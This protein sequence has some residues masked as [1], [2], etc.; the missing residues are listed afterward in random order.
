[1]PPNHT[2]SSAL[3]AA[4]L[5]LLLFSAADALGSASTLAVVSGSSTVCGITAGKSTQNISCSS[6]GSPVLPAVPFDSIS[7]GRN[8]FCGVRS[9]GLSLLCWNTTDP[10]SAYR[11]KRIYS[12]KTATVRLKDPAVGDDHV[13]AIEDNGSGIVRCWRG[14]A[15]L[16]PSVVVSGR[17]Q[18]VTSGRGFSCG[19]TI[20]DS[21]VRCWG[22]SIAGE[23]EKGFANVSVREL[24]AGD[25]HVCGVDGV[26]GLI[27]CRGNND[28][29]KLNAP[30][31]EAFGLSG[32][33]LGANH[34]CAL[35]SSNG[36][37]VCWGRQFNGLTETPFELIVSGADRVCGLTRANFSVM[38]W[39]Q[40][41]NAVSV[42]QLPK[43]I[44]G[45][46]VSN[47]S[48][49]NGCS[50]FPDSQDLCPGSNVICNR[51][52]EGP[53]P[54][55]QPSAPPPLIPSPSPRR[56]PSKELIAFA[57]VGSVGTLLGICSIIYCLWIG[58]CRRKKIHNSVLPTIAPASTVAIAPLGGSPS[59]SRSSIFNRQSSRAVRRQRSGTSSSKHDRVAEE[60]TLA[61]L[62]KA[63]D[64][65]ATGNRIG[66]G[67]FG[68]VYKGKLEDGREVAIKRGETTMTTGPW[69]KKFLE[70]ENAFE[71]ELE[72]LSRL[73][74]KHLVGLVGFCEEGEE[75]LL[76][77]EYMKNGAL[78]DH[79]HSKRDD[80]IGR[81]VID[82]WKMRIKLCLDAARGI[83]YLHNYAVPPIIH[84]DIKSSNILIDANWVARVSDFGLSLKFPESEGE[85]LSMM[86]AGTVGYMD[87]E[88]YSLHYLTAKSDVY[89]LGV[90]LL[91][92]LTGRRAIFKEA[93][94][95]EPVSVVDYAVPRIMEGEVRRILDQKV[96]GMYGSNEGEAVELVAYVALHCVSLEGK[97]RPT[98]ADVVANLE[99]ALSLC[100]DDHSHGSIS[101]NDISLGSD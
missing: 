92:V 22:D 99:R 87:P 90:V 96:V 16:F 38:C 101:S 19:V 1:M 74:H 35:R 27:I 57:V 56:K 3:S 76:V 44:P 55:T 58:V 29:G 68:T 4:S 79:L 33:A 14:P 7:G 28:S 20:N 45:T 70:K 5:L 37:V 31:G 42:Q 47:N 71:S 51:C 10:T 49:C 12:A 89:G 93:E 83:E 65:F 9:G 60:F 63:A 50:V 98:M 91:E 39:G 66:A 54:P 81:R 78:Y 41:S 30:L 24:V 2:S 73:H 69:V 72:F 11:P 25:S 52:N 34:S 85:R 97:D 62:A 43:I 95:A 82:S 67:S 94:M 46:C 15:R 26:S 23:I 32:L 53:P 6:P 40:S 86:A 36:S 88:Y 75:R 61:E 77:Y 80:D 8:F 21:L 100:D 64:N 13:C 17:F 84:R 48:S 59:R 18:S